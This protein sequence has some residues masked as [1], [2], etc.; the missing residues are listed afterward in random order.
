MSSLVYLPGKAANTSIMSESYC[1]SFGLSKMQDEKSLTLN[2]LSLRGCGNK[3]SSCPVPYKNVQYIHFGRMWLCSRSIAK[4]ERLWIIDA[5][6][7]L[8]LHIV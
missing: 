5:P 6:L 8:K 7:T 4:S 2:W 1:P 3:H